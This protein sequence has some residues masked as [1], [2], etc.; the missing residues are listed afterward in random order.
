MINLTFVYK[1]KPTHNQR[2]EIE[3]TLDVC[4]SVFNFALRERK[5]WLNSR[6]SPVNSCSLKQEYIIPAD[7]PYPSY[8]NQA[9]NLTQAKK[10][11]GRLKSVHSQ[12]L[13]Q[14]L[15]QL[16]RAFSDMKSKG[17]G[18]PRFKKEMRSFVFPSLPKDCLG[19][20]RIKLP[21]FG[22]VKIKQSRA[23]P[24]GFEPKQAR[25]VKKASGY[26]VMIAFQSEEIIPEH[27]VG[28]RSLGIDAGIESFIATSREELI[29]APKFLRDNLRKLRLL[30]KRLRNKKK[31]SNAW[32]RI[33]KKVARLH[34][35]IAN[36]RRDE[37]SQGKMKLGRFFSPVDNYS[38]PRN[39][40]PQFH[41]SLSPLAAF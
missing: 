29:K 41:F 37:R 31:G 28:K 8:N 40:A 30:Q 19:D 25:I 15:K 10:N 33:Q 32:L 36:T 12:V 34:E 1:I 24:T 18:F 39:K 2:Q 16:D 4:R 35:K 21:K 6:K 5:D 20:N 22:W 38:L 9:K 3:K 14:T 26:Y 11:N 7:A 17:F 13:Q 23:Y 27:S